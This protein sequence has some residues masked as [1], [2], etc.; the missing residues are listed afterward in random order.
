MKIDRWL[1][2]ILLV[3]GVLSFI[4]KW[5]SNQTCLIYVGVGLILLLISA[6]EDKRGTRKKNT[7]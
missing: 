7:R 4:F 3:A 2:I 1:G 5:F 6:T